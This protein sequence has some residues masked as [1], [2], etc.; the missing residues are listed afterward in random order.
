[1]CALLGQRLPNRQNR[2]L[3][4]CADFNGNNANTSTRNLPDAIRRACEDRA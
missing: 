1:M 2:L 4:T 3:H